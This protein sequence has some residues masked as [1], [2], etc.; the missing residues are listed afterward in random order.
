MI[1]LDRACCHA[2]PLCLVVVFAVGN[3]V[4]DIYPFTNPWLEFH[5][6]CA[7]DVYF[8]KFIGPGCLDA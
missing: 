5:H 7:V 2:T 4:A 6:H 8:L 3:D 1:P